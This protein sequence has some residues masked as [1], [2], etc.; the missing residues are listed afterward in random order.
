MDDLL[1]HVPEGF[2]RSFR[3]IVGLSDA[4]CTMRLDAD[5][6]RLCRDMAAALCQEGSPVRRGKPAGWAAGVVHA[7]GWVNFLHDPATQPYVT[8]DELAAG[9]NV[10]KATMMAKSRTIRKAL[11]LVQFDP[12]WCTFA[13]LKDNP[14]VWMLEVDGLIV[15]I[16]RAPPALQRAAYKKGLIP[17][18]PPPNATESLKPADKPGAAPRTEKPRASK[19][20][21]YDGPTLFDG[22]EE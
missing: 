3:A 13:M 9:F 11:D 8:A 21:T 2:H 17:F 20:A 18:L 6:K 12:D 5:Y 14:R 1:R 16:R 15:D 10:S 19:A 22:L 4:F 7:V